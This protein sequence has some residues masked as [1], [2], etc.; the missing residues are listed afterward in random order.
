[1][2]VISLL[3]ALCMLLSGCIR[4]LDTLPDAESTIISKE[5]ETPATKNTSVT[6]LTPEP[7][8][9]VVQ[10]FTEDALV[11]VLNYL[12]D[13]LVELKYATEDNFT[14]SVVYDSWEVFLRYGTLQKLIAAEEELRELGLRLKLWDGFRPVSAQA[15]LWAHFPDANYVSHPETGYRNHCRGNAVDVTLC[16]AQGR[17]L[18]MP[19]EFDD[20][21]ERADWNLSDC[22]ETAAENALLLRDVMEKCGFEAYESEWW[23]FVD[24]TE[25]AVAETFEP[26]SRI[27][28]YALCE[29]FITLRTRPSTEAE[30]VTYIP[31]GDDFVVIAYDGD[32]ALAEYDGSLLGYVLSEYIGPEPMIGE[33][34]VVDEIQLNRPWYY[35]RCENFINLRE[36]ADLNAA[37][38]TQ[39]PAGDRFQLLEVDGKFGFVDYQGTYG[40]V[41][42]EY[43]EPVE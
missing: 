19:S 6:E 31:A 1:M 25:Y 18:E 11:P 27:V 7:T 13:L 24:S 8:E 3:L 15:K 30:T 17:E 26:V 5:E 12:P 32:F 39:I 20:F 23:H 40:Y 38:I 16:D 10:E 34:E 14:G 2:R 29:E 22:S 28:R 36:Q 33:P 43:I 4:Q 35:A 41:V 42:L 9:L 21:S 37:V